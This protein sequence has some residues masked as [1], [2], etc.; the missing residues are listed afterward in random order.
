MYIQNIPNAIKKITTNE[1]R[2]IFESYYKGI[3]FFNE[4]S[5][6]SRK[7]LERKDL[8][9]FATNVIGKISDPHNAKE[10]YRSFIRK[11]NT[12]SVK[13][14]KII[15]PQLKTFKTLNIVDI[16][17]V[18]IEQSKTF[19]NP[20]IVDIKSAMIDHPKTSSKLPKTIRQAEKV[21]SAISRSIVWIKRV[22]I[23]N[24]TSA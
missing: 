23:R 12:K 15:S 5:Y 7:C 6:Y 19:V 20:N 13:Q 18:T 2:N 21:S 1:L 14:S 9:W 16:K 11:K 10:H 17:S 4:N 8:L 22:L 24:N 3:R